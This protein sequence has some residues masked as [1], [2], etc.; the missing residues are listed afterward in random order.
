MEFPKQIILKVYKNL[1]PVIKAISNKKNTI[2]L[3]GGKRRKAT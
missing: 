3:N 2:K 1:F